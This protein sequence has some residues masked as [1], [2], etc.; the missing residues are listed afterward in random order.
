M[1]S[2]GRDSAFS[3]QTIL[4]KW[5]F[6]PLKNLEIMDALKSTKDFEK[7][8]TERGPIWAGGF[9]EQQTLVPLEPGTKQPHVH[10]DKGGW[11]RQFQ[12]KTDFANTHAI[13]IL[14]VSEKE[15]LILYRDPNF[16]AT[17]CTLPFAQFS[18]G[19][20][21]SLKQDAISLM[22]Y[23]CQRCRLGAPDCCVKRE[24][25]KQKVTLSTVPA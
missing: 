11:A 16:S 13:A 12:L 1:L 3:R 24:D 20:L 10:G 18:T 15:Q 23:D 5:D 22:Y 2:W 7:L 17:V 14:G 21:H 19:M 8:L 25:K 9:F 6:R 4:D